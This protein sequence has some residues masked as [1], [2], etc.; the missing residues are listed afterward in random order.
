MQVYAVTYLLL[1]S[2][3]LIIL[4]LTPIFARGRSSII[5]RGLLRI[6]AFSCWPSCCRVVSRRSHKPHTADDPEFPTFKAS[7]RDFLK[8]SAQYQRTFEFKDENVLKKIAQTYRLQYLKDVVLARVIDDS[9]FNVLNSFILF[10]Q[11]DIINHIIGDN[12]FLLDLFQPFVTS[13]EILK[14]SS[15]QNLFGPNVG[16]SMLDVPG[17]INGN[18]RQR[19]TAPSPPPSPGDTSSDVKG[20][21]VLTPLYTKANGVSVPS[22][23]S[24]V[25]RFVHQLCLMAKNVQI[26]TRIAL[27]RVLV[28]RGLLF[29]L[30]WALRHHLASD[31]NDS[32][33]DKATPTTNGASSL[34]N[35]KNSAHRQPLDVTVADPDPPLLDMAAEIFIL[36]AEFN[37]GGVRSHVVRQSEAAKAREAEEQQIA[38]AS[39]PV[40]VPV[41]GKPVHTKPAVAGGKRA[42]EQPHLLKALTARLGGMRGQPFRNQIGDAIR[43][44]L[45]SP[46]NMDFH[47]T[48]DVSSC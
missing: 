45:E 20:E 5:I 18:G 11:I 31:V 32:R 2:E 37:V 16:N 21:T 29:A 6:C 24:D 40:P 1:T 41:S 47:A 8:N 39:P 7:Y 35:E 42:A 26:P 3:R 46:P 10:N 44:L 27:Y 19:E 15:S 43:L 36:V 48:G 33:S 28:E 17:L 34:T 23:R 38:R 25:I 30:E 9:T 13:Q 22:G 14:A 4:G 12:P